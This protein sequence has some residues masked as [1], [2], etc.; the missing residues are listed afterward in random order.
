MVKQ[1]ES[2]LSAS[3]KSETCISMDYVMSPLVE[4]AVYSQLI[5]ILLSI[6][7]VHRD[8]S[9]V[10]GSFSSTKKWL[11]TKPVMTAGKS[12]SRLYFQLTIKRELFFQAAFMSLL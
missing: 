11:Q 1:N 9:H 7:S 3:Q 8:L 10:T 5:L 2:I 6:C 12:H 4:T